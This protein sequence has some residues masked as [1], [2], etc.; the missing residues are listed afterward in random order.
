MSAFAADLIEERNI[1]I[2][3][4]NMSSTVVTA[5]IKCS[6]CNSAAS[7][8][9]LYYDGIRIDRHRCLRE[10]CVEKFLRDVRGRRRPH[11]E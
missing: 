7:T 1:D 3:S 9:T 11:K 6:Y 5:P 10:E 4:P 2:L 8:F